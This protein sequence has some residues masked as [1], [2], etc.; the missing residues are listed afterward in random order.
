[1]S[2]TRSG[3]RPMLLWRPGS[4]GDTMVPPSGA[5]RIEGA[6]A[7]EILDVGMLDGVFAQTRPP[8]SHG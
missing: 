1:M 5:A 8:E 2:E 6:P 4:R 7:G 3:A